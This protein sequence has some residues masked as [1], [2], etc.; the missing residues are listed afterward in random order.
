MASLGILVSGVAHEINNPNNFIIL[1][2]DN[3]RDIWNDARRFLDIYQEEHGD[4]RLVGL[5]YNDVREET[6]NLI[7]GISGGAVRI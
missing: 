3:L 6:G 5:P 1:N 2:A 7:S 4:F